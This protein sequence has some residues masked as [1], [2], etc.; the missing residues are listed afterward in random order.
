[1]TSNR[2]N[3]ITDLIATFK[4][5]DGMGI[6]E[7]D[8]N[9]RVYRFST[10][11][12]EL[13]NLPYIMITEPAETYDGI[14]GVPDRW[15]TKMKITANAYV[16]GSPF[17]KGADKGLGELLSQIW[18]DMIKALMID[19]KRGGFAINTKIIA[20]DAI[21]DLEGTPLGIVS[22]D[23]EIRYRFDEKDPAIYPGG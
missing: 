17:P 2:E 11:P 12:T 14:G 13:Q 4:L 15:D 8:I 6:Y 1:M 10:P 5:I 16:S 7:T 21:I 18:S 9:D 3:V 20:S 22:L 19:R 23:F